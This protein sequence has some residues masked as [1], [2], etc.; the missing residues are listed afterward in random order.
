MVGV[1]GSNPIAPTKFG[2]NQE[3]DTSDSCRA[4]CLVAA[5]QALGSTAILVPVGGWL[6]HHRLMRSAMQHGRLAVGQRLQRTAFGR[7]RPG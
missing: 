7:L 4:F 3:P 5:L 1:V 2:R 6:R